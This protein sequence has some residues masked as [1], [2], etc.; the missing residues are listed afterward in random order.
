MKAS[1]R[2]K[3]IQKRLV[4]WMKVLQISEELDV[5]LKY[6][7]TREDEDRRYAAIIR[8]HMPYG[9]AT[10]E[11]Y[12][13]LFTS[14][15]FEET[16]DETVCHE[17]IHLALYPLISYCIN[18]FTGDPGKQQHLEDLEE[19]VVTTLERAL[20]RIDRKK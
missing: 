20:T 16:A 13:E 8:G 12:D 4:Y 18:M 15:D 1:E 9:S 17:V 11:I 7:T 14:K 5:K 19:T 2:D 3:Y 6:T 10:L